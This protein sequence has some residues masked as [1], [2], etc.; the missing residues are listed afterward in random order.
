MLVLKTHGYKYSKN[1]RRT[2]E[3]K[4]ESKVKKNVMITSQQCLF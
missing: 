4:N 1:A 2:N 3:R